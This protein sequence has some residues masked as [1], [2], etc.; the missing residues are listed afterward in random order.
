MVFADAGAMASQLRGHLIIVKPR[1]LQLVDSFNEGGSER[2]ALQLTRLLR[3][4]GR[5]EV[6]LA[7][8]NSEGVLRAEA[9]TLVSEIPAYP[10]KSFY[11]RNAAVQ[12]RKFVTYLRSNRIDLIHTH[13]FYTNI[14]GMCAGFLAGVRARV[15]SRRETNGMRTN[16]QLV[17]QRSAYVLAHQI[18]ANSQAVH[19]KL[20]E[21]GISEKRIAVIHNGIDMTRLVPAFPTSRE[22]SLRALG[23]EG[24]KSCRA[25]ITI[26][27]N[28]R[29][30]VKDYPMFL[31]A[32]QLVKTA[33]PKAGFLLAGEG[34]L[35]SS[36]EGLA[37]ELGVA[38]STFF[39]GRCQNVSD[40]LNVS[41]ICAL[42]SKAE[43]FSNSILEYM[44]AGRPVVSTNVGGAK[45]VIIEGVTGH[46]VDSGE[47]A[48]MA[49][50]ITSLLLNPEKARAM[51]EKGTQRV[52][53]RFSSR[54]LLENTEALY[55]RL[56][57]NRV[58]RDDSGRPLFLSSHARWT[59]SGQ[60]QI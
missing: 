27:A 58:A 59:N 57:T 18:V 38:E 4:C 53:Q 3:D 16:G 33:F 8:L 35:R 21:E 49:A 47:Y 23:L 19:F 17:L 40:L 22:E 32:A 26:V 44:A 9:Q 7:A 10:L 13:D 52:A 11:D 37:S 1:I 31:R 43:G 50:K 45:E 34:P 12:L 46:L 14:F 42:S 5:Y 15:A 60:D 51:G 55:D 29:H 56:L 36:I 2:Q 24:A 39:L 41:D 6:F 20:I 25:F 54:A 30:E 28:M 48:A